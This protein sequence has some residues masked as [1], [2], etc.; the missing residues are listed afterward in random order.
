LKKVIILFFCLL[1]ATALSG[2]SIRP[3]IAK[4]TTVEKIAKEYINSGVHLA[5]SKHI[6]ENSGAGVYI[7]YEFEDDRG[8]CFRVG[9]DHG[10]ISFVEPIKPFYSNHYSYITDYKGKVID[11]YK[12]DIIKLLDNVKKY[13]IY[14]SYNGGI[15]LEFESDVDLS[16]I[17]D[18]IMKI[19][20]LL[21]FDYYYNG[22]SDG[23]IESDL[24]ARWHSFC[25]Y[26]ILVKVIDDASG[27]SKNL[28][29]TSFILSDGN[30]TNLTYDK[31]MM[32][33][34][35]DRFLN[36]KREGNEDPIGM[37]MMDDVLYY[38][39]GEVTETVD[40]ENCTEKTKLRV[41]GVPHNNGESNIGATMSY[42]RVNDNEL[43]IF[44]NDT[45]HIYRIFE[46]QN[47]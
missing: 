33:L 41:T 37:F 27:K 39:T 8:I 31:I 20:D 11:Y 5:A 10:Y 16:E 18:I 28:I 35:A 14:T 15:I 13:D 34:R 26:D 46:Y 7:W 21:A 45:G 2:C 43:V 40:E 44:Y 17:A 19:N 9:I 42:I 23:F 25:A 47:L 32:C 1:L 12:E 38:D 36:E 4:N 3:H 29:Y 24:N 22:V 30:S 6:K